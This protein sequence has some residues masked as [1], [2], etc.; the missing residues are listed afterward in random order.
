M[1]RFFLMCKQN[2]K[3]HPRG[4]LRKE[5]CLSYI[6]L[7]ASY[8]ASQLYDASHRDVVLRTVIGE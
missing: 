2:K 4:T 7:A 6:R 1:V 8:I 5:V 3:R